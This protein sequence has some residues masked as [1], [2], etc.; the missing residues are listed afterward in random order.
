M[1]FNKLTIVGKGFGEMSENVITENIMSD[2]ELR[3]WLID[4]IMH[5]DEERLRRFST[6]KLKQIKSLLTSEDVNPKTICMLSSF[7]FRCRTEEI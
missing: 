1:A 3:E 2:E 4:K 6:K 5:P 7:C